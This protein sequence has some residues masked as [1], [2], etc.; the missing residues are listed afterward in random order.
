VLAYAAAVPA[1]TRGLA[2]V[3]AKP[4][5]WL[6]GL[7]GRMAARGVAASLSRTG[8]AAAALVVAVSTTVGVDLM[9]RSFRATLQNWLEV[10]LQADLYLAG[11]SGN[12][13]GLTNR[14]LPDGLAEKIAVLP[15]VSSVS[16]YRRVEVGSPR[17]P[18]QLHAVSLAPEAFRIFRFKDGDAGEIWPSFAAGQ[19]VIVSEPFAFRLGLRRGDRVELAADD[20]P[21]ALPILGIHYDYASDRGVV[22]LARSAYEKHFRDRAVMSL[23]VFLEKAADRA[24]SRAAVERLLPAQDGFLLHSNAD[25]RRISLAIFDRTFAITRV[26]RLLAMLVAFLGI[27]SA[28]LALQLERAKEVATLRALGLTPRQLFGEVMLETGL[29]GAIAGLLALPLGALLAAL[30]VQV[31]NKRSFGWTLDLSFPPESLLAAL[32]LAVSAA[33][34][35]GLYPAWKMSRTPPARAL[36]EE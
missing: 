23:G 30:L 1:A 27:V 6:A 15:G 4:L 21:L 13:R 32:A 28:L 36:R 26:L 35:S 8:V 24:A 31:I 25:L 22:L 17:G 33:L 29:L 16:T 18:V 5:G 7:L 3:A 9:V 19:G 34:L 2:L 10:T 14:P 20:G 12:A 11:S